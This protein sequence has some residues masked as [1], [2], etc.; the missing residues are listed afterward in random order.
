MNDGGSGALCDPVP[1]SP[2]VPESTVA[3]DQFHE[4]VAPRHRRIDASA[5]EEIYVVGDVHGCR[6]E[7]EDLLAR[8]SPGEDDLVLFVGD[9]VRKGPDSAG[10]VALVR[11]R[12]NVLSIRGN[13][14]D[15]LIH[16]R[17]TLATLDEAD[18]SYLES[19]PVAVS[20][21]DA[22][23][24]HGGID[25]RRPLAEQDVD[26]LLTCR[27]VP[28][29]NGYDG[30]FWFETYEGPPRAFFGHTVLEDP[31]VSEWAVG[32]DTGCVYGGALTAYDYYGDELVSVPARETYRDRADEKIIEP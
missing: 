24:V 1:S 7:L 30:P 6:R 21:S 11:S 29:E 27:A 23:A 14:E 15:K 10:V 4:S 12:E 2:G 17:K 9:L 13:N 32:L 20:W 8:L 26:D 18:L 22:L 19:L 3:D 28:P 16:D 5:W 31:V 25:P